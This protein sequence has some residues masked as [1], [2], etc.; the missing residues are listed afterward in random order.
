MVSFNKP[1]LKKVHKVERHCVLCKKHGGT[2]VA[3]NMSDC[4]NYE[5]DGIPKKG[6]GKGQHDIEA[7]DK[8]TAS[9]FAQLSAKIP[10]LEKA[11]KK[12]KRSSKKCKHEYNS[13]SSD[14]DS[15]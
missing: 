5:K 15:S 12:L 7:P 13:D 1:I 9:A 6:F 2:H 10:K 3:H 11:N 14:S 4:C 8:K